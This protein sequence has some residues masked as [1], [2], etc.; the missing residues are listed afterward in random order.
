M[1]LLPK[2]QR[3]RHRPHRTSTHHTQ[4][5]SFLFRQRQ[6]QKAKR[7]QTSCIPFTQKSLRPPI[8]LPPTADR[9]QS[10][11]SSLHESAR[12]AVTTARQQSRE[13]RKAT[14]SPI[15]AIHPPSVPQ[16]PSDT[17]STLLISCHLLPTLESL[18]VEQ[19]TPTRIPQRLALPHSDL[20]LFLR[21]RMRLSRLSS[22]LPTVPRRITTADGRRSRSEGDAMRSTMH[23][24]RTVLRIRCAEPARWNQ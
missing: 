10:N 16:L 5:E 13:Q 23:V 14:V 9:R 12:P 22:P 21:H 19:S 3:G 1:H 6:C 7:R 20:F 2:R 24:V 17:A 15:R 11:S 18:S 4:S 8:P